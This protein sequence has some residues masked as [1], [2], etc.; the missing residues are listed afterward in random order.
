MYSIAV[1]KGNS[2]GL[3]GSESTC[4]CFFICWILC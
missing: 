4:D 3:E 2:S 1:V